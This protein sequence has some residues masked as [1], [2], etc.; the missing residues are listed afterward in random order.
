M[1]KF[2]AAA[3]LALVLPSCSE[4]LCG[5]VVKTWQTGHH[6]DVY[7]ATIRTPD[8]RLEAVELSED[9]WAFVTDGSSVCGSK[10]HLRR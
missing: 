5:T 9:Q 8:G 6:N 2:I 7:M 3:C 1:K 10:A 4:R